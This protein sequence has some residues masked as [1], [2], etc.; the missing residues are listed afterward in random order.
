M[1]NGAVVAVADAGPMIHL[2]ETDCLSLLEAFSCIHITDGVRREATAPGRLAD[3]DLDN[4]SNLQQHSVSPDDVAQYTS[5]H[6]LNGL[7][8]GEREAL[9]LC[10]SLPAETFLTDDLAAREA[11][12]ALQLRPVGSLGA[13]VYAYRRN[14]ASLE[15]AERHITA[16]YE[17]SSLFVT[18]AIVDIAIEK[19]RRAA[20]PG[21]QTA[22]SPPV[23]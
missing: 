16:L 9:C 20:E 12:K 22:G 15:D 6:S 14:R 23:S 19:L 4:L 18:R 7:E 11:A 13:I 5:D 10:G 8:A 2:H 21:S 1:G 3:A 17:T